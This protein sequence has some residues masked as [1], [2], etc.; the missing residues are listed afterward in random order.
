M[1]CLQPSTAPEND[2]NSSGSASGRS[3]D[4]VVFPEWQRDLMHVRTRSDAAL[5]TLQNMEGSTGLSI[6]WSH[7]RQG[8]HPEAYDLVVVP[9]EAEEPLLLVKNALLLGGQAIVSEMVLMYA[10]ADGDAAEA[11]QPAG[12]AEDTFVHLHVSGWEVYVQEHLISGERTPDSTRTEGQHIKV[13]YHLAAIGEYK[14]I[15]QQHFGRLIFSGLYDIVQGIY[16]FILGAEEELT[17]ARAL[18]QR[19]GRKVIVA[20]TSTNLTLYERFTLLGI[21]AHLEPG[22]VFLYMHSKGVKPRNAESWARVADWTFYMQYFVL[23]QHHACR[24]LL[25]EGFDL[26]G[27]DFN[28]V[29]HGHYS[30]NFWWATA[31]YYLTLPDLIGEEYYEPEMYVASGNPRHAV[32]WAGNN[33]MYMHEYPPARY[34]DT[35]ATALRWQDIEEPKHDYAEN[36]HLE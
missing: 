25:S 3:Q 17:E 33:N 12:R 30:G 7:V 31:S 34:V 26:C 9:L 29:P 32:L 27:V 4:H 16:C 6:N 23:K 20:G 10:I 11:R 2:S 24:R 21:R 15:V 35:A 13:A 36:E 5:G 18:L 22:D 8:A 19:Y 14:M 28:T 1:F